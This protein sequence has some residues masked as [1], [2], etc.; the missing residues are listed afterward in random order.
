VIINGFEHLLPSEHSKKIKDE[1]IKA[2][3]SKIGAVPQASHTLA[4]EQKDKSESQSLYDRL[5]S[6]RS[7]VVSGQATN[8]DLVV[9]LNAF[10][11]YE[12]KDH[13]LNELKTSSDKEII[14][15][16]H[17]LLE[18]LRKDDIFVLSKGVIEDYNGGITG[19][20]KIDKAYKYIE[21]FK[22]KEQIFSQC[23]TLSEGA[24]EHPEFELIFKTIFSQRAS[25]D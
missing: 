22:S 6:V 14:T 3:D 20:N 5:L 25:I 11:E 18:E 16:K 2:I 19:R 21:E 13:R 7:Q 4:R 9:A 23:D 15:L 12:K 10:F 1:L 17:N 8:E 24:A